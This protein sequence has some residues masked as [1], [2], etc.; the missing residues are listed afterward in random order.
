VT[1]QRLPS[2]FV[3]SHSQTH[4]VRPLWSARASAVTTPCMTGRRKLVKLDEP[5]AT[6]P[7]A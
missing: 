1:A 4:V 2:S 6:L 3:N 5:T 7:A